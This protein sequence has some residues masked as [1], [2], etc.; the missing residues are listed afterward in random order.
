MNLK[1]V[2]QNELHTNKYQLEVNIKSVAPVANQALVSA[3]AGVKA[4]SRNYS[5]EE[6]RIHHKHSYK[7]SPLR[8]FKNNLS[9]SLSLL[10]VELISS[11]MGH[12]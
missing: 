9:V 11:I 2:E 12:D 10:N 1:T 7:H 3:S 6:R 8:K 5:N 4:Q